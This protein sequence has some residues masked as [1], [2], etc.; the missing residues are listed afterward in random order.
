MAVAALVIAGGL[1][2]RN[3]RQFALAMAKVEA[4]TDVAEF[5]L[6]D[7]PDSV[8]AGSTLTVGYEVRLKRPL[9]VD[10]DFDDASKV[11]AL[12]QPVIVRE[13]YAVRYDGHG[14]TVEISRTADI[15]ED[16][17]TAT[18][19]LDLKAPKESGRY[20]VQVVWDQ[21]DATSQP[22]MYVFPDGQQS[23]MFGRQPIL[24]TAD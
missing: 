15:S 13:P 11:R 2:L 18:G 6:V 7:V 17:L 3:D 23:P 21:K 4:W 14:P 10:G 1:W 19:T 24:V 16:R 9:H 22:V 20:L 8:P 12:V 5:R